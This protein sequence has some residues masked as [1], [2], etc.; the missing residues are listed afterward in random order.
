MHLHKKMKS[1]FAQFLFIIYD[2]EEGQTLMFLFIS[3]LFKLISCFQ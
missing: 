2:N 1:M 3:S